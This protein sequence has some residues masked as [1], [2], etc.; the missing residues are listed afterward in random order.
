MAI[1]SFFGDY[2]FLSNFWPCQI[3]YEGL[4]YPSVENAYQASKTIDKSL[5]ET[6]VTMTSGKAKRAGRDIERND[7]TFR[8][9]LEWKRIKLEVM[10]ELT[11]KK[12]QNPE[13]AKLLLDTGEQELIEGNDWGDVFYGMCNGV[14]QNHL[15]KIIMEVR[16]SLRPKDNTKSDL[17][18]EIL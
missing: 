13:L 10:R 7:Q 16:T 8:G 9:L 6:F 14:G 11:F 18:M 12:Y 17:M 1:E 2:R 5:R 4:V 15:G 3:E